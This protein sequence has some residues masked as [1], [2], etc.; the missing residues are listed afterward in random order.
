MRNYFKF[1]TAIVIYQNAPAAPAT[2]HFIAQTAEIV[3]DEANTFASTLGPPFTVLQV[4]QTG[5]LYLMLDK[6][7]ALEIINIFDWW[8]FLPNNLFQTDSPRK[9]WSHGH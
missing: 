2:Q 7:N 1:F 9:T 6:D 4:A 3:A 8:D 5:P